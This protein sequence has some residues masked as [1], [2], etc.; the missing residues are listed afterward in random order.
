MAIS[1]KYGKDRIRL[2]GG[3]YSGKEFVLTYGL[4]TM[5]FS[6]KGMYGYYAFTGKWH[7]VEMPVELRRPTLPVS[8]FIPLG[9]K[10]TVEKTK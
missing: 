1:R 10:H 4:N 5:T 7:D 8:G 3:P 2:V 9:S 6:A